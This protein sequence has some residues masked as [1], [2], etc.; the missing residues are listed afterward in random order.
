VHRVLGRFFGIVVV[1]VIAANATF[2][3]A[4][5]D[6]PPAPGEPVPGRYIVTL[7]RGSDARAV[8]AEH[9][10]DGV[11]VE[12]VYGAALHGFAAS[13]SSRAARALASNPRVVRVEQD[14]VVAAADAA[15]WGLD[16]IDQ[17]ALPL[18]G[19][20][21][22]AATGAGVHAY[23][24][25]TGIRAS[26]LD[27]AGR[28]GAG[29]TAV[30]DGRG[31]EDCNGHGTHVAG[32]LGGAAHGVAKEVTLVPVRVLD[33]EGRGT[34]SGVIAGVD[35]VTQYRVLPAVA[36]MS[37]GGGASSSLDT[38]VAN[39]IA[40]GVT[41]AVAAGNSDADAC[42]AS[43]A[44]VP[45]ALT[46]GA[47]DIADARASYSNWGTCL[48]V[49]AP[50]SGI[51]S[52]WHTDDAATA[53]ISGTSMAS[54]H[55][56]GVAAL[57]LQATPGLAPVDVAAQVTTTA[58]SGAVTA[59]GTGSPN[60]LLYSAP[61]APVAE[62]APTAPAQPAA[63][64]AV[65]RY[66]AA[67]VAWTAPADGGAPIT[68]YTVRAYQGTTL[69]KTVTVDGTTTTVRVTGLRSS[70]WYRFTVT[71]TNSIGASPESAKSSAV[72]IR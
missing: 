19:T 57:I 27:F 2:A 13:M 46:V 5:A 4:S 54:P 44:R 20:Y 26:H 64:T 52:A 17:T 61:P 62:P 69:A 51:T 55:V 53:Q 21:T 66:K 28:V 43:P 60:L 32:T 41:Y 35:W 42:T 22:P 63:P 72:R 1:A 8:A 58:T 16:R 70:K 40:A 59:T 10:R 49:F 24:I 6:A 36:N 34:V 30:G 67:D 31:T 45:A 29:V 37:L 38:A 11:R 71:A 47:T 56:A 3:P 68:S 18:S 39:S 50:G 15:S 7:A 9:R 65:A 23:V 33:C 14:R 48:D 12:R 25:D